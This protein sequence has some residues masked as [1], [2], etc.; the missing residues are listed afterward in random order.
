MPRDES[1]GKIQ[2]RRIDRLYENLAKYDVVSRVVVAFTENVKKIITI[3]ERKTSEW[4]GRRC[5]D[6]DGGGYETINQSSYFS[7]LAQV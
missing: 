6:N 3:E 5:N 7:Q 2:A 1:Q 4:G